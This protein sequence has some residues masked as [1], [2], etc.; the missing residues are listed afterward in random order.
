MFPWPLGAGGPGRA[1]LSM[2]PSW[3]GSRLGAGSEAGAQHVCDGPEHAGP[4]RRCAQESGLSAWFPYF[5]LLPCN[6][7]ARRGTRPQAAAPCAPGLRCALRPHCARALRAWGPA[8][9]V[10]W[11]ERAAWWLRNGVRVKGVESALVRRARPRLPRH[12]DWFLG[13]PTGGSSELRL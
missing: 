7:C 6:L 1:A 11:E 2:C 3:A 9:L 13:K 10:L 5:R 8:C 4:D 12:T